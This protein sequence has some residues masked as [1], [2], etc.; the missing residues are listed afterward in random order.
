MNILV[1]NDDGILAPGLALLADVCREVE[2]PLVRYPGGHLAACHHPLNVTPAELQATEKDPA[3]PRT[4]G[5]ELP[6]SGQTAA[7]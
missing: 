3:S 6:G 2:P 5:N 7:A 1:T 4:A